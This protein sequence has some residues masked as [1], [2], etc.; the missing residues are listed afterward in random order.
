MRQPF[1]W[2]V[3]SGLAAL[4]ILAFVSM[5]GMNDVN[6]SCFGEAPHAFWLSMNNGPPRPL[7]SVSGLVLDESATPIRL[8]RIELIPLEAKERVGAGET[9]VEWTTDRGEYLFRDVDPGRYLVSLHRFSAPTA[10]LPF[11]GVYYP[12]VQ[13]E[14]AATQIGVTAFNTTTLSPVRLHR[15]ETASIVVNVMFEDG[16]R[17]ASSNLLFHNPQFPVQAVI[18]D[19]APEIENGRGSFV[20]PVGFQ[21]VAQAGVICDVGPVLESRESRPAQHIALARGDHPELTFVIPGAAC[22]LR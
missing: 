20:V 5:R 18:G 3:R 13:E 2:P 7:G 14:G 6:H 22:K 1:R 16:V 9:P 15:L 8:A 11:I 19:V 4:S 12:G 17:P 21:Y 10:A